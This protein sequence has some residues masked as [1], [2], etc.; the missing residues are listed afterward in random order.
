MVVKQRK[1]S[2]KKRDCRARTHKYYRSINFAPFEIIYSYSYDAPNPNQKSK[3][4]IKKIN[5]EIPYD[6]LQRNPTMW[7]LWREECMQTLPL[8]S[9]LFIQR[10]YDKSQTEYL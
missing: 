4:K 2:V 9:K 10:L 5:M 1:G 3:I 6:I 8:F 7:G